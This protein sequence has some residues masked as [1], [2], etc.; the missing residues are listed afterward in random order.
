MAMKVCAAYIY[1][2]RRMLGI[3][4]KALNGPSYYH[5]DGPA[6]TLVRSDVHQ[7]V[8]QTGSESPD[9]VPSA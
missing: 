3:I 9:S 4:F 2:E 1:I 7:I 5:E 6:N 8:P